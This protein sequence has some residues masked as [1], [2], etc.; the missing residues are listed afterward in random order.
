MKNKKAPFSIEV[1]TLWFE[2][3][4]NVY[5]AKMNFCIAE[6]LAPSNRIK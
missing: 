3:C 2:K 6:P 5:F 4:Y 1:K